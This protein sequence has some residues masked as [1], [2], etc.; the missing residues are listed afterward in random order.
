MRSFVHR[1]LGFTLIELLVVIAIIAILIGLLLPAVQKVRDAAAR[2]ECSNNL[3]QIGIA[4]HAC[5]DIHG[6]LPPVANWFPNKTAD[7]L[8][9]RHGTI[10]YHLLPFLEQG[11]VYKLSRKS[12]QTNATYTVVVSGV[13][14]T[15]QSGQIARQQIAVFNCPSD[16]SPKNTTYADCNYA[17]NAWVFL[18]AAGG[19]W[20]I[21]QLTS[22]DGTSNM[23]LFGEKHRRVDNTGTTN[24]AGDGWCRWA[25][26]TNSEGPYCSSRSTYSIAATGHG[27]APNFPNLLLPYDGPWQSTTVDRDVFHLFHGGPGMNVLRGDGSVRFVTSSISRVTWARALIPD[28]GQVLGSDW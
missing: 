24:T 15:F 25:D 14:R 18:N 9:G 4:C 28:D 22:A 26:T 27:G 1:R 12:D 20:G 5:N 11:N 3:K 13:S 2:M 16:G 7:E 8:N 6:V 17:A 23:V 21:A 19:T 10:L